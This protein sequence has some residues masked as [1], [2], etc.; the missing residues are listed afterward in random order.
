MPATEIPS[1]KGSPLDPF[2]AQFLELISAR[3]QGFLLGPETAEF[4]S[5]LHIPREFVEAL[6]TSARTRGLVKPAYGRGSKVRWVVSPAGC[7][8]IEQQPVRQDA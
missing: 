6:Y 3:E 1:V 7:V 8:L 2:L 4:A 5:T